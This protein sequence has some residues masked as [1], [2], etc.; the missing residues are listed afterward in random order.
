MKKISIKIWLPVIIITLAVFGLLVYSNWPKEEVKIP[1]IEILKKE[2]FEI[3]ADW[4]TYRNK[5]YGFEV[6]YPPNGGFREIPYSGY[7]DPS[8]GYSTVDIYVG[9]LTIRVDA[10]KNIEGYK[11]LNEA[12]ERESEIKKKKG[13]VTIISIPPEDFQKI[14]VGGLLAVRWFLYHEQKFRINIA[15][16]AFN[17]KDY[18]YEFWAQKPSNNY[19]PDELGR[20][21]EKNY[22]LF[23]STFRF[24]E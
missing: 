4:K 1:E 9:D 10:H 18:F 13:F 6:K 17:E 24:L 11:T 14:R 7:Q 19:I 2:T 12:I 5:R 3:P 20:D 15:T 22:Y 21:E 8:E 23:L 16:I